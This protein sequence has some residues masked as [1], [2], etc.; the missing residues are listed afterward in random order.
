[1]K[2]QLL[3]ATIDKDRYEYARGIMEEII[4]SLDSIYDKIRKWEETKEL[5][6]VIVNKPDDRYKKINSIA[7]RISKLKKIL[8]DETLTPQKRQKYEK[9]LV[10][11][12]LLLA[13]LK[14]K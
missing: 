5:P 8:K 6:S 7:P 13:K 12:E 2:S 1:M 3:A 9:E 4:P 11:K 10:D 14:A